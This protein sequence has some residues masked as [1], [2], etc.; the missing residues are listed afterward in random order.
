M[1]DSCTQKDEQID[2]LRRQLSAET[3]KGEELNIERADT[4]NR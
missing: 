2:N 1:K 4:I 3:K